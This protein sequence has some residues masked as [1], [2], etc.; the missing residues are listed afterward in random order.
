MTATVQ[1]AIVKKAIL[2]STVITAA[3]LVSPLIT[4]A[5]AGSPQ[6]C[7]AESSCSIGEFLFDDEYTPITSGTCTI[8]SRYPDGSLFLNSQAMT[9]SSD[10]WY[11]YSF[12]TPSTTGYYRTQVCCTVGTD[13]LCV[14]KAFESSESSGLTASSIAAAVWGYSSRTMT[15]F[16][17]LVSD[18]WGYSSRS[19]TGFGT[20]AQDVWNHNP[21]K[22]TESGS[23]L[24]EI[25]RIV[26]EN[27]IMLERLVNKPIV[28][29][30]IEEDGP[31]LS[32]ILPQSRTTLDELYLDT[33]VVASKMGVVMLSWEDLTGEEIEGTL[34]ELQA[35]VGNEEDKAGSDSVIG[36]LDWVVDTWDWE[37]AR[38]ARAQA[39]ELSRRLVGAE[40]SLKG[41]GGFKAAYQKAKSALA[42]V[43]VLEKTVGSGEDGTE[44]KTVYSQLAEVIDLAQKWDQHQARV[45]KLLT[46][47]NVQK[48][49]ELQGE[50]EMVKSD[51]LAVNRVPKGSIAINEAFGANEV[52][53]KLKNKLLAL[54]GLIDLNRRYI[55]SGAGDGM[56]YTWLEEGS[57][58]F[59]SVV[60][61]PSKIIGQ[62]VE[63][64]YYLPPEVR[65]E[66]ILDKDEGLEVKYDSEKDQYYVEGKFL[67]KASESRT[68]A[69]RVEDI[70]VITDEEINSLKN[71]AE[72]LARP[73]EKT[74]F[75][76]QGVTLKSD[77]DVALDK[78]TV[79]IKT[80]I[81]PEQKIR[82]Y[83]EAQIE[84]GGVKIKMEKLKDLVVQASATG[85]LL[86]FVGGAQALAVWGLIIILLAGFVFLAVC[87]KMISG[88]GVKVRVESDEDDEEEKRE[89]VKQHHRSGGHG[90]GWRIVTTAIVAALISG[91]TS[92]VVMRQMV[93]SQVEAKVVEEKPEQ[94]IVE[95][96]EPILETEVMG[97]NTEQPAVGGPDVVRIVVEEGGYVNFRVGP[98]LGE[99][100]VAKLLKDE[101]VVRVS[102]KGDW[103]EVEREDGTVGWVA[104]KFVVAGSE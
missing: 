5:S 38:T 10:G 6:I 104:A 79:L 11:A 98:G 22:L 30:F 18:I 81:T 64:K 86:G 66:D 69:V 27:R 60:T 47:W 50:I 35:T 40:R 3:A 58:I 21:R 74:A 51:V 42:Q 16:G 29:N 84:M 41:V 4:R 26:K 56:A 49:V 44:G 75:F 14:D 8:T 34:G 53:K 78:I 62:E 82:S 90:T 67:L 99:E 76:A 55:V 2:A 95:Q 12:T 43:E 96:V 52:D 83:R 13:Y 39:V 57:V 97:E 92:G 9:G 87:M 54:R 33:Q 89:P 46:G 36:Q 23:N 61:N 45:D 7:A 20:L 48:A 94:K 88:H 25:E 72:E 77:I 31:E 73:L 28:Q 91:T 63:V 65:E 59:K 24:S 32:Q 68:L 19:M 15:G 102:E 80:A 100:V 85:G 71:Q 70:W 93:L 103:V 37:I 101:E 1:I 17:T